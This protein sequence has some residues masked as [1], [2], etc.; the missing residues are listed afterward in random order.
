M[1]RWQNVSGVHGDRHYRPI[2]AR[3]S[4]A[5]ATRCKSCTD[6]VSVH[7]TVVFDFDMCLSGAT[8][9]VLYVPQDPD[10]QGLDPAT[11]APLCSTAILNR[12]AA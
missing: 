8:C 12:A 6:E 4:Q 7:K 5:G 11:A 9:H 1:D 3:T 2:A 10:E